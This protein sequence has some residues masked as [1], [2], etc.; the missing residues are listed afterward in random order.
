MARKLLLIDPS[1]EALLR[2]LLQTSGELARAGVEC[3]SV[4]TGA[5]AMRAAEILWPILIVVDPRA[6]EPFNM[7][8]GALKA[9]AS[10]APVVLLA[11]AETHAE[12]LEACFR[13]G[14]DDC[15]MRPFRISQ[16]ASRLA[17]ITAG[18]ST[19]PVATEAHPPLSLGGGVPFFCP[20][21]L[22]EIGAHG[23]EWSSAF[24]YSLSRH[25]LFVRTLVPPRPRASVEVK[26]HLTTTREVIEGTTVVRSAY[27]FRA[28]PIG[29]RPAGAELQFLGMTPGR[30][31]R[32]REISDEL[33]RVAISEGAT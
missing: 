26:I 21:D 9:R 5:E 15:V 7:D 17:A 33:A 27:P 18:T 3:V 25:G 8:C 28:D 4:R 22:R 14:A 29:R 13:S 32:L 31:A 19:P 1:T 10:G 30:L 23:A 20:V 11:S 12:H 2:S 24:S 16:I 6:L